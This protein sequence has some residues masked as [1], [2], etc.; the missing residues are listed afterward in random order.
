[1]MADEAVEADDDDYDSEEDTEPIRAETSSDDSGESWYTP[2]KENNKPLAPAV[3]LQFAN[4]IS[5]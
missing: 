5:L 3:R 4:W 2:I 1:M